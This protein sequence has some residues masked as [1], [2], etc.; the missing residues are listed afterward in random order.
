MAIDVRQML[1]DLRGGLPEKCDFC[2]KETKPDDLHPEEAGA[3]AC[4]TCIERWGEEDDE[5]KRA[6]KTNESGE[7]NQKA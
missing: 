7:E 4:I 3:W 5:E 6:T 1:I 2:S